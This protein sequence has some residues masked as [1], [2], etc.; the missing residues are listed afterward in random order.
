MNALAVSTVWIKMYARKN[1]ADEK[2]SIMPFGAV[3]MFLLAKI[4][5]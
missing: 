3:F 1:L 5:L 4:S 2:S